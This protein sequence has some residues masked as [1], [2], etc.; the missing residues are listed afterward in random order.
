MPANLRPTKPQPQPVGNNILFYHEDIDAVLAVAKAPGLGVWCAIVT[1][2]QMRQPGDLSRLI[3][4]FGR[5][6]IDEIREA[7]A[8]LLEAGMLAWVDEPEHEG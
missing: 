7:V 1:W 3:D 5:T 2:A 6:G 8:A 4:A